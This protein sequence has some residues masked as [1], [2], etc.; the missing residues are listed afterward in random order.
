VN[1]IETLLNNNAEWAARMLREDPSFFNSL[2]GQQEPELLWI[3]CSDSRV[4]ANQIVGMLPGE[5][6]VHRNVA[7]QVVHTDLNALSVI[8][9]AIAALR[10]RHIIVCGHYGCGGVAAAISGEAPNLVG[11]W[12]RHL[13]DIYELHEAALSACATP[14]QSA[15]ALCELNVI[16]QARNVCTSPI[17]LEAWERQQKVCVHA[18]IYDIGDGILKDLGFRIDAP[19]A[20]TA[21]YTLA[22]QAILNALSADS[23]G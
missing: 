1:L 18:W 17:L 21:A 19:G 13:R 11:H 10:V 3:G 15:R 20:A 5:L 2:V 4:P 7:N 9:Y 22:N 8:E 23:A 16:H 6:F 14:A 12:L